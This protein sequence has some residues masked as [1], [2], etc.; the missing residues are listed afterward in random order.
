[1][2]R[3]TVRCSLPEALRAPRTVPTIEQQI[4]TKAIITMNHRMETVWVTR[5]PQQVLDEPWPW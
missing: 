5:T 3:D 1:M 2:R 4:P